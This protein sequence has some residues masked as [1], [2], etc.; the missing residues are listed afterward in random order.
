MVRRL[1]KSQLILTFFGLSK[2]HRK[3]LFKDIHEICFYGQGGYSW[4]DVYSMPIW[5][6]NYTYKEIEAHYLKRQET[7]DEKNNVIT[8][9]TDINK[10]SKPPLKTQNTYTSKVSKK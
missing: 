1:S 3:K 8:N 6:R 10:I 2:D 7:I 4:E 5:L 9:K